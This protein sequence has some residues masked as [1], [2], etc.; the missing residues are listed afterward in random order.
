MSKQDE[1]SRPNVSHESAER[2]AELP[3]K[4]KAYVQ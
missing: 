4:K 2:Y 1:I 3:T